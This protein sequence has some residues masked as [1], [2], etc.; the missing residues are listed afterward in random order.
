WPFWLFFLPLVPYWLYLAL[1]ARSLTYFTAANPGIVHS[2]VF[3]ESKTEILKKISPDYL[4]K[5]IFCSAETDWM[6]VD[7]QL[8]LIGLQYP[9]IIKPDVGERGSQVEKVLDLQHLKDYLTDCV[10]PFIIQE[11][12]NLPVELGVLY[13]RFPEGGESGFTSIVM[14]EFLT[15]VGDGKHT[16]KQLIQKNERAHLQLESLKL[17]F[18]DRMGR[19][20]EKDES[21]LLQPIG[22]HCKGTKFLSG[23]H[24]INPELV[25]V[26]DEI[27]SS[28]E[29]FNFGRFDLKVS[30][31]ED[32]Q[33]GRNIKI[34]EL[35]G[36]TSE[37]AHIYDPKLNL[38]RAYLDVA[39][40]MKMMFRVS[41]ANRKLGVPVTPVSEMIKLIRNHFGRPKAKTAPHRNLSLPNALGSIQ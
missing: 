16:L 38:L 23:Q 11:F 20:L 8:Q 2:G 33:A 25:K 9:I 5:T 12:L 13:Y 31:I 41:Q 35:N 28:I 6:E 21:L 29:G 15:V 18:A 3:G 40:N 36:V 39:K 10:E 37:P 30:S 34:M 14:K 1:R 4:P 24:L 32:L 17:K 26:F 22:N 7:R 27:A 19:V